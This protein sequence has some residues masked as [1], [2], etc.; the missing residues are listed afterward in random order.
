[1]RW[2]IFS[3]KTLITLL[4][5]IKLLYVLVEATTQKPNMDISREH[6][7]HAL[8]KGQNFGC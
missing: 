8:K 5:L 4:C 1:M 7:K 6:H 2:I 3:N